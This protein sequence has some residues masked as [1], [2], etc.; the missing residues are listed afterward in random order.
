MPQKV[1]QPRKKLACSSPRPHS[2]RKF[3][4]TS[5]E[6]KSMAV[7]EDLWSKGFCAVSGSNYGADFVVYDGEEDVPSRSR[8]P[9][10]E[11]V[12]TCV[13]HVSLSAWI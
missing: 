3:P 1:K 4:V 13:V 8:F 7:F 2:E 10:A 12:D 6:K 9:H 11:A 5:S